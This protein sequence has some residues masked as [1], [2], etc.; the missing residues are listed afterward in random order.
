LGEEEEGGKRRGGLLLL[1]LGLL[2]P[3]GPEGFRTMSGAKGSTDRER[4]E[5]CTQ[6]RGSAKGLRGG[7]KCKR[8]VMMEVRSQ[9]ALS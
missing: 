5:G 3:G 8:Q 6:K 7:G 2:G 4:K 1:D 9:G